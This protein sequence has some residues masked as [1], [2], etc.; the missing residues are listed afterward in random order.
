MI[1]SSP[2]KRLVVIRHAAVL[3]AWALVGSQA[4]AIVR[5]NEFYWDPP[6]NNGD[7]THEYVE[8]RGTPGMSLA[9]HYLIVLESEGSVVGGGTTGN[10]D[11]IFDLGA[12]SLGSTGFL[13]LRQKDTPLTA[14]SYGVYPVAAG[15]TN[16]QNVGAGASWGE[17]ATSSVGFSSSN[18]QGILENA[19]FTVMLVRNDG[20]PVANKPMLNVDL[21][22]GNDGLDVPTGQLGWQILDSVGVFSE[23]GES[24]FGR[25]YAP[26]TFSADA[27]DTFPGW[28]PADH[29]PAGGSYVGLGFELEMLARWGNSFGGALGNWHATNLTNNAA[30]GFQKMGD[31]RQSGDP[32]PPGP[33][34]IL[35]SSQLVPYGTNLTGNLGSANYPLSDPAYVPVVGDFDYDRDVDATDLAVEFSLRFGLDF[36][37]ADL[38]AWQRQFP[39]AAASLAA[40]V[41]PEPQSLVL[42]TLAAALLSRVHRVR[43]APRDLR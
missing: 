43:S 25:S 34:G 23:V 29:V 11:S 35:E 7:T 3:V 36:D 16:L 24:E 10:I 21:D 17:G 13:T 27:I 4:R 22:V 42:L 33:D 9:N 30:S 18:G 2:R 26:V 1:S 15:S 20:D 14:T 38:L 12:Y 31:L 5:L 19:A 40:A 41:V 37:G 8:L 32:H 39:V 28:N 6:G